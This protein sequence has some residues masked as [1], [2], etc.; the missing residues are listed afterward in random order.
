MKKLVL[1]CL[2]LATSVM[3]AMAKWVKCDISELTATDVVVIVDQT[4]G[5]A[6]SNDNGTSSAPSAIAVTFN[7]GKTELIG[8]IADNV[9]WNITKTEKSYYLIYPNDYMMEKMLSS[10]MIEKIFPGKILLEGYPR[11]CVFFNKSQF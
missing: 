6:M 4:S 10:Y 5:T 8:D 3:P 1:L 9:K 11:N 7:E 2:A